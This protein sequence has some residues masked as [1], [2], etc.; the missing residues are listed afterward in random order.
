MEEALLI[1]A[2]G[3]VLTP[4]EG[5]QVLDS[6]QCLFGEGQLFEVA[7]ETTNDVRFLGSQADLLPTF[8]FIAQKQPEAAKRF[9]AV[10]K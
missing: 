4:E 9:Q 8:R 6:T 7:P 1:H 5:D 3:D 10:P 2:D